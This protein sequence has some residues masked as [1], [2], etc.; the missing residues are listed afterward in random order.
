MTTIEPLISVL[1]CHHMMQMQGL[2]SEAGCPNTADE[3]SSICRHGVADT[4]EEGK[5]KVY[6]IPGDGIFTNEEVKSMRT[7][8]TATL[9]EAYELPDGRMRY[10]PVKNMLLNLAILGGSEA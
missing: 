8:S 4:I 7:G 3:C 6:F 10:E 5:H 1:H 9:Y 2:L